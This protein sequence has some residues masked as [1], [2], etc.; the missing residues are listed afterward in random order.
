[1]DY[2]AFQYLSKPLSVFGKGLKMYYW[3]VYL[4]LGWWWV[5]GGDAFLLPHEKWK[6][7]NENHMVAICPEF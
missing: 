6:I 2:R 7:C 4:M 1:M 3:K 5:F